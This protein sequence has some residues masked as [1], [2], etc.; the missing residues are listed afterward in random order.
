MEID[1]DLDNIENLIKENKY[2][3]ILLQLP[4]GLKPY[5]NIIYNRLKEKF[6]DKE[7]FIWFGTDFGGCDIP[8]YMDKFGFDLIIH[9]GHSK[10]Y[11]LKL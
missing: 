1:L 4:D 5:S 11:K 3:K 2:K 10:F 8:I 6:K 9:F 7:L